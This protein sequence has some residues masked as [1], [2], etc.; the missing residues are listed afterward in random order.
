MEDK[1]QTFDAKRAIQQI[2]KSIGLSLSTISLLASI[3]APMFVL[4]G[5]LIYFS[6]LFFGYPFYSWT[7]YY[8]FPNRY[9]SWIKILLYAI[10]IVS[11]LGGLGLFLA[12]LITFI[13]QKQRLKTT[14]SNNTITNGIYRFI[15]HPQNL[16]ICLMLVPFA[17]ILPF[18]YTGDAIRY[19]DILSLGLS[20]SFLALISLFEEKIMLAAYPEEYWTYIQ[21]TSFYFPSKK[22]SSKLA[23][24]SP[25]L[26]NKYLI[27]TFILL[28][29]GF[30]G[31]FLGCVGLFYIL[32]PYL[33]LMRFPSPYELPILIYES[34]WR[35]E[36]IPFVIL[37]IIWIISLIIVLRNYLH[38]K[39]IHRK[40]VKDAPSIKKL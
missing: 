17:V 40:S 20:C 34:S 8:L 37:I 27:K 26:K 24:Y 36:V 3:L 18:G 6:W 7:I 10:E 2:F 30:I 9:P 4:M 38:H 13:K 23:E 15:R 39:K 1:P 21:K 11:F 28:L 14:D 22:E 35:K 12:G 25:K 16:G 19:G 33:V 29:L 31:F 5:I 32:K